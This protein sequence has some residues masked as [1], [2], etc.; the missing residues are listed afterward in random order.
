M[1]KR[2]LILATVLCLSFSM[3]ACGSSKSDDAASET[4]EETTDESA[5]ESA[6]SVTDNVPLTDKTVEDEGIDAFVTLGEYKGLELEKTVTTVTDEEVETEVTNRLSEN[7]EEITDGTV[8]E[9]DIANIDYEG[10]LDGVAFE[11]GTGTDFDLTIGSGQFIDGFEDGLVGAKSGETKDINLTFPD[12]YFN[13]ELAGKE[14]VFTVTV[15]SIKRPAAELTEEWV[16]ANTDYTTI[17]EYKESIRTELQESYDAQNESSMQSTAWQ[18]VVENCTPLQFPQTYVDEGAA[19]YKTQYETYASYA[20]QD[21]ATYLESMGSSEEEMN[22]Q[23]EQYGRNIAYQRLVLDSIIEK[24][25]LTK[26]Q[27][28]YQTTLDEL[29]TSSGYASYDELAAVANEEEI[30]QTVQLRRVLK[31]IVDNATVKEISE[32]EAAAKAAAAEAA[33]SGTSEE[34]ESSEETAE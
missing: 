12:D 10:K 29:V 20:G 28:D 6:T 22:T 16:Q 27:E 24:E 11:G 14:V 3:M 1:K 5:E 2:F 8:A 32:E 25:G 7:A 17:D 21:L 4:T 34:A 15:N 23:C 18:T 13:E 30:E 19:S 9:G 26:D 33:A 31:L